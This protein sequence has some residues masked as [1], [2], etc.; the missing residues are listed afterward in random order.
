MSVVN[1]NFS[2]G[3]D[4]VNTNDIYAKYHLFDEI[5]ELS[6]NNDLYEE[7]SIERIKNIKNIF[8][9]LLDFQL[10]KY[11]EIPYI[12]L[13]NF[14]RVIRNKVVE[15]KSEMKDCLEKNSEHISDYD[16]L[17][18]A[19]CQYLIDLLYERFSRYEEE[20]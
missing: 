2:F 13:Y 15:L 5:T 10:E 6:E 8:M 7:S 3:F 16:R 20:F 4:S 14:V 18:Y 12:I 19:F 9:K 11:Q 1:G 17:E